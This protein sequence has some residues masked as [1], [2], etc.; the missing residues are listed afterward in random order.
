MRVNTKKLVTI[1][2]S[3]AVAM[4][5]SFVESQIPAF[6]PIPGIKLG[7]ANV[8][9]VFIL[10][11]L[12]WREAIAVSAVRV[13]LSSILFGSVSAFFY[14]IAG[15]TLSLAVMMLL[16]L[17][18]VFSRSV[19]SVAGGVAHNIAQIGVSM[20]ILQTDVVILYL[21]ALIISGI[22]TG[23][24]IGLIAAMLVDKVNLDKIK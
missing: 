20:L 1:A 2:A 22:V 16:K 6:F 3:V 5:L 15:A 14:A 10:Y 8:A 9:T 7:L 4:L 19:V 18:K 17:T 24:V 11:K 23:A 21:P 13:S 12:G